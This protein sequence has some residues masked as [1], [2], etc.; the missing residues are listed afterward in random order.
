LTRRTFLSF[1]LIGS[2]ALLAAC[3]TPTAPVR[4]ADPRAGLPT[5][6]PKPTAPP[7]AAPRPTSEG[8]P[9]G[10]AR[11]DAW[12]P[13]RGGTLVIAADA[14][15]GIL[16]PL[17]YQSLVM[18]D[19]HQELVP[20]LAE[21]WVNTSP[22]TWTFKLRQGVRFHD[23]TEF[24]AEDVKNWF[25]TV[26]ADLH[27]SD[28]QTRVKA[29]GLAGVTVNGPYEIEVALGDGHGAS[30]LPTFAAL[31]G[32]ALL[33]GRG[34]SGATAP[35]TPPGG[36]GPFKVAEYVLG[37]HARYAKFADYWEKGLPYLDE[38]VMRIV[39]DEDA[40][41][42]ALM[43]GEVAYA[44]VGPTAAQRLKREPDITV[45]SSPGAS[46]Q[47]TLF[48]TQ[49]PPFDDVR[50]RRAISLAVDRQAAIAGLLGGEGKLTG[51][52]PT[53][54]ATWA[55]APDA[56]PYRRDLAM[57]KHLLTEAGHEAG[58]EA[59]VTVQADR[60]GLVALSRLLAEQV[61]PLGITLRVAPGDDNAVDT[62]LKGHTFDLA[63][64][65]SVFMPD[66]DD[67][68]TLGYLSRSPFDPS[69]WSGERFGAYSD[70]V[71]AARGVLDPGQRRQLYDQAV[72]IALDEVPAIWWLVEN[73]L[74][75]IRT[76]LKG[77]VPSYTGRMP[78]LK[79]AWLDR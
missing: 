21:T 45:L 51:P 64:V 22:T 18:Y 9:T 24:Q 47:V 77:Y 56:L 61:R 73:N 7:T 1:A 44:R 54:L 4:P 79:T 32:T 13:K 39:G 57:A 14:S 41:V 12:P 15:P 53:G 23:G 66:P 38:I 58:F 50:V 71:S 67:Y 8:T 52:I 36:T 30:L 76:S 10:D 60:P 35:F 42:A 6:E 3:Q 65:G 16:D 17:A 25:E 59:T 74:E 43:A 20:A 63:T 69:G 28:A 49:R 26:R 68:L 29:S 55:P 11:A 31:F 2:C 62:A 33:H 72:A 46:Q 75:A 70:L 40:R 34:D 27:P 48:N 5:P 19:E 37:S 78:G